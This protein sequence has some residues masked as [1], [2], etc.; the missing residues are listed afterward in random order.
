MGTKTTVEADVAVHANQKPEKENE[1]AQEN[2]CSPQKLMPSNKDICQD[3]KTLSDSTGLVEKESGP[4]IT[5]IPT[6]AIVHSSDKASATNGIDYLHPKK[7]SL[8]KAK[9]KK[10]V[11]K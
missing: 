2:L 11:P 9:G 1:S 3:E 5:A 4:T 6:K 10:D 7:T 8:R